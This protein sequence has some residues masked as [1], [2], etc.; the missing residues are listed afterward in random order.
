[1]YE[2]FLLL[3]LEKISCTCFAYSQE[4]CLSNLCLCGSFNFSFPRSSSKIK[5]C[6]TGTVDQTFTWDNLCFALS[7]LSQ[8]TEHSI[9]R[10]S[11][12][13]QECNGDKTSTI[14]Q[15][16]PIERLKNTPSTQQQIACTCNDP[17][18]TPM[19]SAFLLHLDQPVL[20]Q[21]LFLHGLCP[22]NQTGSPSCLNTATSNYSVYTR[23]TN[24]S[25]S[26]QWTVFVLF[27]FCSTC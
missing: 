11:Q 17:Y 4:I 22:L 25:K 23:M 12:S 27:V 13:I 1:M 24:D 3:W 8:L 20:G 14:H 15:K 2:K 9:S 16:N 19:P 7:G 18:L 6:I 5:W 21:W 26:L 10:V